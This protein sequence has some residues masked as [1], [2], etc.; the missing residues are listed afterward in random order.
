M[1]PIKSIQRAKKYRQI[2]TQRRE[3]QLNAAIELER[4]RLN[5][6]DSCNTLTL[7]RFEKCRKGD[8]SA[9]LIDAT[10]QAPESLLT[11][12]WNSIQAE[13]ADLYTSEEITYIRGLQNKEL[14]LNVKITLVEYYLKLLEQFGHDETYISALKQYGNFEQPFPKDNPE[15]FARNIREVQAWINKDKTVLKQAQEDIKAFNEK[16][17]GNKEVSIDKMLA[18]ITK[19]LG[20]K[21]IPVKHETTVAQYVQLKNLLSETYKSGK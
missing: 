20:L 16:N 18:N 15:V 17:A 6:Y 12:V 4:H 9:L 10:K 2:R 21:F 1:N 5:I 19:G 14:Y 3:Q 7:D 11:E 13:E 8:L